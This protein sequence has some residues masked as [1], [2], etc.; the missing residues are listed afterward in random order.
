MP[1]VGQDQC[2]DDIL[3]YHRCVHIVVGILRMILKH[4]GGFI[5]KGV[6]DISN[7]HVG[8]EFLN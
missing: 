1:V 6:H 4:Q 5:L 2:F 7:R 3:K 8:L